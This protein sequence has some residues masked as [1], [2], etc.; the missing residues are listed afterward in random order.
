MDLKE[1]IISYFEGKVVRKD[2]AEIVKGNLPVPTYVV[3]YL[4]AQYCALDDEQ[5]I[6]EGIEKVKEIIRN[7]YVHRADAEKIKSIIR[8]RESYTVI[9]KISV[10]LNDRSQNQYETDF[11]NLGI[12]KIPI[13]D[14]VVRANPKLLSGN[15]VW[16]ILKVTYDHSDVAKVR[17]GI[18]NIKPIQVAHIDLD[19][20]IGLREKFSTNEWIDLLIQSIGI[21]PETL[22][23]RGKL[24]QISRLLPHIENNFN[25]VE[26]GPKGTGKSHVFQELSPHGVLVSGGDVTSARL[27]VK[28]S[29]NKEIIGLVGYWDVV[30]WDEYEHQAGKRVDPVMVDTIQNYLANKSFN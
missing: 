15:G 21:K 18:E 23:R 4:L 17:W 3:E 26:L 14:D 28:H 8:E 27:F 6:A 19:E 16:S 11:A 10:E 12:K 13:G 30:A 24:I 20:F 25:Y 9:D 2:L 22:N 1:K 29:G 7:N 5:L